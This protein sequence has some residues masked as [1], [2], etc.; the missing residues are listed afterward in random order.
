EKLHE[1]LVFANNV[2]NRLEDLPVPTIS[3]INGYALGGG[4]EC[5]LATDFRVA[6]PD[7]RIGLPETK[8]GIMPG[9]GGSVRLPRLLGNDSALEIIAAGKDV[10][11]KDALKV[12]LVDAVV[13][14][15][16]LA[17]AA[18]NMLQQA[19]DGKL[20]WRAA[21]QPKLEPLKLSPIEAAMSF[22]TAKGMVLQTAG[23]HYPAPM[24]AVKTIEAAA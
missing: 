23:K 4:C 1:W 19:I 24:T 13:A 21:R 17:E 7:A 22:T 8:L 10:S 2:F 3:A 12:G 20:D 16:K 5:I 14:P 15:E 11:A 9:F 6:S 18:L